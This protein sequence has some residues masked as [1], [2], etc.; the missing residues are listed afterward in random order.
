MEK[1]N[2]IRERVLQALNH[3]ESDR[4]PIDLGACTDSSI[5]KEAY[6]ELRSFLGLPEREADLVSNLLRSVK[7]HE[8]VHQYF[9]TDFRGLFPGSPGEIKWTGNNSYKDEWGINKI[10]PPGSYYYDQ[11]EFPLSGEINKNDIIKYNNWPDPDHPNVTKNLKRD[12]QEIKNKT[13]CAIVLNLP[14]PFIHKSQFLRG[15]EDWFIDCACNV[16]LIETLFDTVL[17]INMRLAE[18][19]LEVIGSEVDIAMCGDDLGTQRSLQVSPEFFRNTIKPRLQKYFA[20]IRHYSPQAKIMFHSCGSIELVLPDLIEIGVD[21]INPV[22]VSATG[23]NPERLKEK[24]GDRL[25][26]WGAID[27][28]HTLWEG[29][30][31]DVKAEV[32]MRITQLA[33]GGGYIL[34]AVHN[35]QPGVP[36]QNIVAMYEHAK[37][38]SAK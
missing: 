37:K 23:M 10:K 28:Q 35:I 15:F 16:K 38:Y 14:S 20:L 24:Y 17:E 22:Q 27:T 2:I 3:C 21:I 4:V 12:F 7:V 26:F 11:R 1:K 13:D 30:I 8:D 19:I 6:Y 33:K 25:C 36:P 32:E 5:I 31:E 34:G 29:S 18:N 9:D